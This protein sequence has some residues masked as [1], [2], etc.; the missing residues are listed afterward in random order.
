MSKDHVRR[1]RQLTKLVNNLERQR[2]HFKRKIVTAFVAGAV[3]GF[4]FYHFLTLL[5]DF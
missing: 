1:A 5:T 4:V 2:Q 3:F